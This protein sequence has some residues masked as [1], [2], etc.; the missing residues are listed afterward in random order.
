[1]GEKKESDILYQIS[2]YVF[3]NEYIDT[4]VALLKENVDWSIVYDVTITSNPTSGT[5][6]TMSFLCIR[7]SNTYQLRIGKYAGS[8][9]VILY[10]YMGNTNYQSTNNMGTGRFRFA[11]I[12]PQGQGLTIYIKKND[13]A[14]TTK[15]INNNFVSKTETLTLGASWEAP[16]YL[17]KG[18]LNEVKVYSRILTTDEINEFLGVTE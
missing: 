16:Q 6:A 9:G 5:G 2:N 7:Q 4:G 3:D 14:V 10:I 1:M 18:T 12:R 8:S 17:T 11:L 13:E 15:T